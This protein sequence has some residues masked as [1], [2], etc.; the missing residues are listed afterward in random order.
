[1]DRAGP[2]G[3]ARGTWRLL[4]SLYGRGI[5]PGHERAQ[6]APRVVISLTGVSP[7]E[8]WLGAF[9]QPRR[10]NVCRSSATGQGCV[11][12]PGLFVMKKLVHQWEKEYWILVQDHG[13]RFCGD[14]WLLEPRPT[15]ALA[16]CPVA[17]VTVCSARTCPIGDRAGSVLC[18]LTTVRRWA[19]PM[20]LYRL[21][22]IHFHGGAE[23]PLSTSSFAKSARQC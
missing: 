2:E 21:F 22:P 10:N 16:A 23:C 3:D 11:T 1:M 15:G 12:A 20:R 9:G 8:G 7:Q 4:M 17:R 19:M 6:R 13:G 14:A 18:C 5:C